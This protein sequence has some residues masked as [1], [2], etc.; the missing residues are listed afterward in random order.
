MSKRREGRGGMQ[1][2]R[3]IGNEPW[4]SEMKAVAENVTDRCKTHD[5][6]RDYIFKVSAR[7]QKRVENASVCSELGPLPRARVRKHAGRT[8]T[9]TG[10]TDSGSIGWRGGRCTVHCGRWVCGGRG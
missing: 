10:R 1:G 4:Q 2:E 7:V 8:R 6:C 5:W 9:C 3:R